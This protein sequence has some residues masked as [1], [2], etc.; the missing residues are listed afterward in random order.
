MT[1]NIATKIILWTVSFYM[2]YCVFIFLIQ[3]WI[4]FPRY[5]VGIPAGYEDMP[6]LEKIWIETRIGNIEAWFLSPDLIHK[7]GPAPAVIFAHGNGEIIDSWPY[8]LKKFN[9]LGMGV[10][11]VEYPGYG[12][13]QG[14]PSQKSITEA[15]ASAYDIL[16][17][18]KDVDPTRIV[19]FGNS[20]GGGAV[21]V[22]AARRPSAALIL[23]STFTSVR[24][25]SKK[26]L[27]PGF[28]VR[29]PFDN[30]A[31]VQAYGGATL[32]IHG[33]FD[34]TIPYEHGIALH[35]AAGHASMI[36][37]NSG[38]NDCPPNWEA[39]WRDVELFLRNTG[40]IDRVN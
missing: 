6:D 37:Y 23:M 31:V 27:V 16:I 26:Y 7:P 38:H 11:M 8:E 13:S 21:C 30:L 40:I 20:L 9:R 5:L 14:K 12:R 35:K 28:I 15:F 24:S 17:Q 39:F 19:L 18:R 4:L 29:D 32:I 25:F 3:R 2:V 1:V 33:R 36:T 22:L 10:L 34:E